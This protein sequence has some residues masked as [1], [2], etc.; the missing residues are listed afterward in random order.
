MSI[1]HRIHLGGLIPHVI[2]SFNNINE[3]YYGQLSI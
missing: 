2:M 3:Q 1:Y